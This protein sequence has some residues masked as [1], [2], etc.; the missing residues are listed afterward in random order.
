MK[1]DELALWKRYN[2]GDGNIPEE[3]ILHYLYLVKRQVNKVLIKMPKA[4]REDLMQEG[5]KGLIDAISKYDVNQGSDFGAYAEKPIHGAIVG[6]SEV[7]HDF[8]RH[9]YKNNYRIVREVHDALMKELDRKPTIDEIVDRSGLS[10]TRVKN[11]LSAAN[12]A[13]TEEIPEDYAKA[14]NNPV[15]VENKKIWVRE[16]LQRLSEKEAMILIEYYCK[17]WTDQ[18]IAEK[19]DINK[20]TVKKTR[21]RAMGK[22]QKIVKE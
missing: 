1:D 21:Q 16:L 22:L 10:Q 12:I 15:E 7:T 14:G 9:Q 20:E 4:S 18:E 19:F 3:L 5:M 2:D 13:F 8:S 17:G 6:S 11:A